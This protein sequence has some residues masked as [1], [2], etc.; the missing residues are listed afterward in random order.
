MDKTILIT[1]TEINRYSVIQQLI[2]KQITGEEARKLLNLKS[3]KQVYRIKKRVMKEG[4][5][6]VIHKSRDKPS[7]RKISKKR[8]EEIIKIYKEKYSDFKP[9]FATE[10]LAEN[11]QIKIDKETLRQ[12]LITAKLWKVKSR[13]QPKKRHTWRARKDN[14]GEMQQFDGSYHKW[15]EDRG[16]EACLLLTVDDASG[17]ITKAKFDKNE[18]VK[19]VF[20]FWWAYGLK[21][22]F[23][24]SIYLDKFSTYKINHKS[25]ED[26]KELMTQFQRAMQQ[27]GTQVIHAHSAEA[28]GRVERIFGTLQ[29]RLVKELRLRNINTIEEANKYLEEEYIEKFNKQFAVLPNKKA[30][31]HKKIDNK[32]EAKLPQIFSIQ[33]TRKVMNDYTIM[34]KNQ[35]FQLAE[36]QPTTVFKKDTV[37]I[38]EHLDGFTMI[39]LK[40][41]YLGYEVLPEKPKKINDVPVTALTKN[42]SNWKPPKDHPWKQQGKNQIQKSLEMP[43]KKNI[44]K[45]FNIISKIKSFLVKNC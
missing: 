14:Y 16:E 36:K 30:D 10:K 38:E 11:H 12:I 17:E 32:L 15:F 34:Y 28:K 41:H 21:N 27:I 45:T 7:N 40:G 29:D 25:A 22:G 4:E 43:E 3:L 39:N 31:L 33:N 37:I 35:Y 13:K 24:I 18:G 8:R 20:K 5:K 26:N 42:K 2:K 1:M 44:N 23:P 9:T 19:A 6:G